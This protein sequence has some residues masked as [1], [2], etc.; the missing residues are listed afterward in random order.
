MYEYFRRSLNADE[1]SKLQ[2][3]LNNAI[4]YGFLPLSCRTIDELFESSG[5]TLFSATLNNPDHV[6]HFLLPLPR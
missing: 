4:R 1:L 5:N 6:F 3:V 2:V